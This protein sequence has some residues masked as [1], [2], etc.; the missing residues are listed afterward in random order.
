MTKQSRITLKNTFST[1][2]V[3]TQQNYHD[4]VESTLNLLDTESQIIPLISASNLEIG[5]ESDGAGQLGGH[6]TASGNLKLGGFISSSGN[7]LIIKDNISA[8]GDIRAVG[9]LIS[10]GSI[11]TNLHITASG[12]ISSSGLYSKYLQVEGSSSFKGPILGPLFVSGSNTL[13]GESGHITASGNISASG[14][15]Y[16]STIFGIIGTSAAITDLGKQQHFYVDGPIQMTGSMEFVPSGPLVITGSISASG[17]LTTQGKIKT[18]GNLWVSGSDTI[19]NHQGHITASGNISA[20]GIIYGNNLVAKSNIK[21]ENIG[22]DTDDTVVILNGS[23]YLR[24]DEINSDVWDTSKNFVD[25]SSGA[26]NRIPTFTDADSIQGESNLT[27][28]GSTLNSAGNITSGTNMTAGHYVNGANGVYTSITTNPQVVIWDDGGDITAA[29][30]NTLSIKIQFRD[31]PGI[32]G[33]YSSANESMRIKH[34]FLTSQSILIATSDNSNNIQAGMQFF[35]VGGG[36]ASF[37]FTSLFGEADIP[38]G[39][40]AQFNIMILSR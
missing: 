17:H 9:Q 20:S 36:F 11:T 13:L 31:M 15:I 34:I 37:R 32:P 14:N 8:S 23:G 35:N 4:F 5:A 1:G 12:N 19:P 10:T 30:Y 29:D 16:A 7:K 2:K 40:T 3:P 38:Q 39:N 28:D 25:A 6:I 26:N 22:S 24:T 33:R 21:A 18:G 27:F